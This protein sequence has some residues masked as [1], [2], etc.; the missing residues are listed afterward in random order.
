MR[1]DHSV[2]FENPCV[3]AHQPCRYQRISA[4]GGIFKRRSLE[5]CTIKGDRY[6]F[7]EGRDKASEV[8]DIHHAIGSLCTVREPMCFRSSALSLPSFVFRIQNIH[9]AKYHHDFPT[10]PQNKHA[11]SKRESLQVPYI[12]RRCAR[13]GFPCAYC[14]LF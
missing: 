7:K 13:R 11:Y 6:G 10:Q 1:L 8:A 2:R 4:F 12:T 3:F 9:N 5:V 14:W